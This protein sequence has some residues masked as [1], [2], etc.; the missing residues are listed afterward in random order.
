MPHITRRFEIDTGHRLLE[1]EGKCRNAHGHRYRFD[2]TVRAPELDSLGRVIDFGD[3]KTRIGQQ[4]DDVYDHAFV[5]EERDP[6]HAFLLETHHKVVTV[7]RPPTI[8]HLVQ[9]VAQLAQTALE[10]TGLT[11]TAVRG[12]ETPN[13]WADWFA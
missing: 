10:G 3:L 12:Y 13:C 5:V 4:L 1:H 7:H 11:V 9:D 2:I 8:E 6:L